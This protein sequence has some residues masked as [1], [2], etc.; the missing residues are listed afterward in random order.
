M[1]GAGI[2]LILVAVLLILAATQLKTVVRSG[3]EK[4]LSIAF[5][6]DVTVQDVDIKLHEGHIE[7]HNLVVNNPASFRAGPAMEFGTVIADVELKTLFSRTP[8]ITR[9]VVKDAYVNLRHELAEGANLLM[10]ARHAGRFSKSEGN[11][12]DGSA[13]AAPD[14]SGREYIIKELYCETT[15]VAMSSNIIPKSGL[16]VEVEP[17]TLTGISQE[18]PVSTAEISAI[19]IRSLIKQTLSTKG[20]L[21]PIADMLRGEAEEGEDTVTLIEEPEPVLKE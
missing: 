1:V 20:L 13:T 3:I 10:L 21:R 5:L 12:E 15:T 18:R 17:F 7:I 14:G 11:G 19:F 2:L 16:K 4:S 6:T 9:V 8:T